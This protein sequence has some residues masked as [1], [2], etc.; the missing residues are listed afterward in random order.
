MFPGYSLRRC[1]VKLKEII[2]GQH[3]AVP[4]S[5]LERRVQ[6]LISS[7]PQP[8]RACEEYS[9]SDLRRRKRRGGTIRAVHNCAVTAV[10]VPIGD[11][12]RSGVEIETELLMQ[13]Y[14]TCAGCGNQHWALDDD[15][16]IIRERSLHRQVVDP[17]D[18]LTPLEDPDDALRELLD[19]E[20][21]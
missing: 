9:H 14:C 16:L 5:V 19:G 3:Y 21:Q 12:P 4:C 17:R 1:P 20:H 6:A 18:I 13:K 11:R 2:V 15:G 7:S 10:G 8:T